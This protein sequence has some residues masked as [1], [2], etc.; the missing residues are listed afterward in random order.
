MRMRKSSSTVNNKVPLFD[1]IATPIYVDSTAKLRMMFCTIA[2]VFTD[3]Q[4]LERVHQFHTKYCICCSYY[5]ICSIVCAVTTVS[6]VYAVFCVK[7]I[8]SLRP[9]NIIT[10][11]PQ[12]VATPSLG[13]P[14][15]GE[16]NLFLAIKLQ[17]DLIF[18][19]IYKSPQF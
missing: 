6:I 10:R 13:S 11:P 14:V 1:T 15:L 9:L 2:P 16:A 17:P 8:Y 19:A 3:H 12:G 7:L 18:R 5:S 4:R